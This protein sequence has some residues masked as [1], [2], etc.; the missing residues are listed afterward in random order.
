MLDQATGELSTLDLE[1]GAK[2]V[3]AEL[4]R[5]TDNL[6]LDAT[7]RLFVSNADDGSVVE[8]LAD[9]AVRT[10]SPGGLILPTGVAVLERPGG[11]ASVFVAD[12]GVEA[13]A[14]GLEIGLPRSAV[15]RPATC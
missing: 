7:G 8:V 2:T 13:I 11:G 9:G 3:L 12:C 14:T 15:F 4:G 6:A 5:G 1:S 10:L